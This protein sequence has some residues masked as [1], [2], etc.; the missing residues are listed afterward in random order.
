[1]SYCLWIPIV[2]MC[3]VISAILSYQLNENQ[4]SRFYFWSLLISQILP[5]WTF[6]AWYS[7][8]LIFDAILYDILILL[9]FN[10]TF[11]C[12]GTGKTFSIYQ[13]CA[14]VVILIGMIVLRAS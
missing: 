12:L 6:V 10:I 11:L 5:L 4:N 1:M 3:C 2:I 14:C 7:K 9:S 13:W 8:N